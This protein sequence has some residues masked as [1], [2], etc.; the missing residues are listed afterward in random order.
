[1]KN[2]ENV[3]RQ[4]NQARCER[5]TYSG[6]RTFKVIAGR[7]I[8]GAGKTAQAAWYMAA[9]NIVTRNQRLKL[10]QAVNAMRMLAQGSFQTGQLLSNVAFNLAQRRDIPSDVKKQLKELQLKWDS[11]SSFRSQFRELPPSRLNQIQVKPLL[12]NPSAE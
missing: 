2:K 4:F 7:K 5:S 9:H 11:L 12:K 6:E 8:L 10:T 1:M 3:Q